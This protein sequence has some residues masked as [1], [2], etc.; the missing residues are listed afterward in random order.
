MGTVF[1]ESF[2]SGQEM[3][4]VKKQLLSI[5]W[6]LP[7]LREQLKKADIDF[8]TTLIFYALLTLIDI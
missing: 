3:E 7:G 6:P 2:G 5:S 8:V 1:L 4:V